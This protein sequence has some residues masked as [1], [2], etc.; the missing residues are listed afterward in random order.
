MTA[1][2]TPKSTTPELPIYVSNAYGLSANR[3]FVGNE[4]QSA[5]TDILG[6]DDLDL[7]IEIIAHRNEIT[8]TNHAQI[9]PSG[10]IGQLLTREERE[11]V[12][13]QQNYKH[14]TAKLAPRVDRE[15][16]QF[17]H[18]YKAHNARNTLSFGGRKYVLP[19]GHERKEHEVPDPRRRNELAQF[20]TN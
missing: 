14:K 11:A 19:E 4:L 5:L 6:Y 3:R 15:E 8:T 18:V 1:R 20:L 12:L 2:A 10:D 9:G 17:P 16:P 13:R 7:V